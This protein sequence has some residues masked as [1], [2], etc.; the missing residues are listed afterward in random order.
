MP[1]L[2][3]TSLNEYQ[4]KMKKE[5]CLQSGY[6]KFMGKI[7]ESISGG[8][9]MAGAEYK[10]Q[11]RQEK[12]LTE[13]IIGRYNKFKVESENEIDGSALDRSSRYGANEVADFLGI[14]RDN[15][16]VFA[17]SRDGKG[18]LTTKDGTTYRLTNFKN[19][20]EKWFLFYFQI[21]FLKVQER[22]NKFENYRKEAGQKRYAFYL[23]EDF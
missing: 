5:E 18:L 12:D 9:K 21:Y 2:D 4:K 6:Q 1:W 7:A 14:D 13:L 22:P 20:Q 3:F 8:R 16:R 19:S 10:F 11:P 23:W 15:V 17:L